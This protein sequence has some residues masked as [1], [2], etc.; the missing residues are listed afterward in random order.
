VDSLQ[1]S[2]LQM[3]FKYLKHP[4]TCYTLETSKNSEPDHSQCGGVSKVVLNSSFEITE[5]SR[6]KEDQNLAKDEDQNLTYLEKGPKSRVRTRKG[7][8][9][10]VKNGK[11]QNLA[12]KACV[13]QKGKDLSKES[14]KKLKKSDD[15]EF[16]VLL[17]HCICTYVRS[18]RNRTKHYCE[19]DSI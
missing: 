13:F 5:I 12:Y 1:T 9:S 4:Q 6:K 2:K 14:L 3:Y 19:S 15:G 16:Q 11:D 7:P 10:R 18:L 8:K 17:L